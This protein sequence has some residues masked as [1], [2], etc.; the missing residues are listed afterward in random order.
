M[1]VGFLFPSIL[2][3]YEATL[4]AH[5]CMINCI[6]HMS[7]LYQEN[8]SL[9]SKWCPKFYKM[10]IHHGS[11]QNILKIKDSPHKKLEH[12]VLILP[13][14]KIKRWVQWC[15]RWDK[16]LVIPFSCLDI[17]QWWIWRKNCRLFCVLNQ[18][19]HTG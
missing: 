17:M 4:R 12:L 13:H 15:K 18:K 2:W 14:C 5:K 11:S 1:T 3:N 7:F 10:Q 19:T 8:F 16:S 9:L 6:S